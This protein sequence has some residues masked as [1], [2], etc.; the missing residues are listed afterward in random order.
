M[1]GRKI[2]CYV[3]RPGPTS[4][5]RRGR[6]G[7]WSAARAPV[8]SYRP[9]QRAHLHAEGDRLDDSLLHRS[10]TLEGVAAALASRLDGTVD[11]P[12]VRAGLVDEG[13]DGHHVDAALRGL[14][15]LHAVEGA[16]DALAARLARVVDRTE[17]VPT[18]LL[19][20]AR[21]ACQ[22]SGACCSGYSFG[23]LTDDDVARLEG[24]ELASA[25][26]GLAPPY[27]D[28]L[29]HGRYLR[30][31]GD[32]CVFLA[33]DRRCGLHAA[34]G[35]DAKPGFCRLY[36][37]DAFGTVEG[38]RVVDRGTCATF[39]VSA[40]VGLPLVDDL[41]RVRPLLEPPLLHHPLAFVDGCPW[42]Y[43]LFLRVT[44]A[45]TSLIKRNLGGASE[46]LGAVGR[47]L[48]ALALTLRSCPLEP[49]QPDDTIG[50]VLALD[51]TTWYA[52]PDPDAAARGLR[53]LGV[54]LADLA[55]TA[56]A[57]VETGT[58]LA[59]APRFRDLAVL[60]EH[61][62]ARLAA[63]EAPP[64][65]GARAADVAELAEVDE[66]LRL[67]M[68]QQ[69][70]GR[71]A[72]TAGHAGAG[73]VRIGVI[74][75]VALSGARTDA[76]DRPLAAADL[77]RGHMLATRVLTSGALDAVFV[78]HE[79]RWRELLDGLRLAAGIARAVDRPGAAP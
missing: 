59:T 22:G 46:T 52:P 37:L 78:A 1:T 51:G 73:L 23:P 69:L 9:K 16:G 27:V 50:R 48:A 14:Y 28:H 61:T 24:L 55:R 44:T 57:V 18:S 17:A 25:F 65:A 4:P 62:A 75:L 68:R 38:I 67:S 79:P 5:S 64:A 6:A 26:P 21:F 54:L 45:A 15:F 32:D 40:R 53:V 39:G 42:D 72:L 66:V 2:A 19:E 13:H 36:P 74:Q 34:F 7:A 71:Q 20:G 47:C 31:A 58:A 63:A 56:T 3:R 43:G 49:G 41:P 77:S 76:G 30:K 8:T 29:A 11:W 70:F 60:L 35:A 33:G 12:T 10:L